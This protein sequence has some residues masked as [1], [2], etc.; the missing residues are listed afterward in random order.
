MI[1]LPTEVLLV[2]IPL[3]VAPI[4]AMWQAWR[5][6]ESECDTLRAAATAAD[7]ASADLLTEQRITNV[8]ALSTITIRE[9]ERDQYKAAYERCEKERERDRESR[10]GS[11]A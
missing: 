2:L 3:I 9:F 5:K 1:S 8:G 6:A 10:T 7:K 4:G 11:R